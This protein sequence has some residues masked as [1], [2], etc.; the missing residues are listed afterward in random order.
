MLVILIFALI[1]S[2]RFSRV[3]GEKGC[4]RRKA[5]RYPWITAAVVLAVGLAFTL[6]ADL[7]L[8]A[9][10]AG[11]NVRGGFSWAANLFFLAAY[12]AVIAR[13]WKSLRALPDRP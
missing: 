2:I 1:A 4:D 12:L 3:A 7:A 10:H 5:K 8:R 13:A 6:S 11:G 9:L